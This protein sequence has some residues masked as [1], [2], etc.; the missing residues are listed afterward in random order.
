[1]RTKTR[2]VYQSTLLSGITQVVHGYSTRVFG[3]GRLPEN[4]EAISR[5]LTL[6]KRP[7]VRGQQTHGNEIAVADISSPHTVSDVDGLVTRDT[8]IVLEVH[9]ADCVPVLLTDPE[10]GIVSAVHAG[11]KGT[12]SHIVRNAVTSMVDAG[13][14]P[15]NIYA[16]IGPH[17]GGCCYTVP[18]SRAAGFLSVFGDDA[19]IAVKYTD[20]WHLD[21]GFA[22]RLELLEAGVPA[23]HID[24]PVLC[25]SCQ[26]DTFFSFRKDSKE[27]FGEIIGVIG[28]TS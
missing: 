1:M 4:V 3:D 14:M 15:R 25:T 5:R 10:A 7:M 17:I 20:E 13:A 2:D 23:D 28:L 8:G 26:V 27:T 12:L 21:I 6:G 22:N 18:D 11:W 19:R 16:S 24:A 9:V